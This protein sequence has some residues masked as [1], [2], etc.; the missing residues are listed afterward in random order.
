MVSSTSSRV[1]PGKP[2]MKNPHTPIPARAIIS[3]RLLI[4]SFLRRFFTEWRIRGEPDSI[5]TEST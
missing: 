5:P 2:R 4:V 1:S 3:T